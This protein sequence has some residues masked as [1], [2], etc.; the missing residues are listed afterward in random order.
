MIARFI[1]AGHNLHLAGGEAVGA[2]KFFADVMLKDDAF[3]IVPTC[4]AL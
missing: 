4:I 2:S 3:H 1:G